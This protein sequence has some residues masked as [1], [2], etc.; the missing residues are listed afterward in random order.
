MSFILILLYINNR[1]TG[2]K[3]VLLDLFMDKKSVYG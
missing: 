2:L 3:R 1:F